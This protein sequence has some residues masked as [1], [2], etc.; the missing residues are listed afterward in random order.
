MIVANDGQ[1]MISYSCFIEATCIRYGDIDGVNLSTPWRFWWPVTNDHRM[2][3][4]DGHRTTL[5]GGFDI[6]H[7]F[8]ISIL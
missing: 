1:F 5:T 8:S 6:Q 2:T 3:T 4:S 7:G